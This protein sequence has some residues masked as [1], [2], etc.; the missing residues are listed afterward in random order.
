MYTELRFAGDVEKD[1]FIQ[2]ER[3][4]Q[5]DDL[6]RRGGGFIIA[7]ERI[8]L[9]SIVVIK[10]KTP[11]QETVLKEGNMKS[12]SASSEIMHKT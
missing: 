6:L 8:I 4:N 5:E 7:K 1:S 12:N 3:S 10:W 11:L 9:Y 2:N